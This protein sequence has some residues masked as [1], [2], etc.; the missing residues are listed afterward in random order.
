MALN[1]YLSLEGSA[2]GKIEGS[3][4]QK[5]RE[6]KI[7]IVA[8][9]HERSL[10]FDAASGMIVGRPR[11]APLVVTKEIDK[12]SPLLRQ[13]F[14]KRELMS[15]FELQLWR[16][17]ATGAETQFYTIRLKGASIVSIRTEMLNTQFSDNAS[18]KE[19]EVV[20]FAYQQ[21]ELEWVS[22]AITHT[23]DWSDASA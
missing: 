10:P 7:M 9:E 14:A 19:R 16:P 18:L 1:A 17:T 11:S 4:T 23:H 21:M 2:Q 6:G 20:S 22:G 5:G 15:T 8:A 12:S 3:V 13:A